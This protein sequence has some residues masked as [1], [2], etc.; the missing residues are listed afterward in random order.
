MQQSMGLVWYYATTN[1]VMSQ[2]GK[3]TLNRL[4]AALDM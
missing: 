1:P 2:W 4:L 3:R